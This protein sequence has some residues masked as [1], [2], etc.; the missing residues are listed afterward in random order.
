MS[1]QFM[2][3][4]PDRRDVRQSEGD[5]VLELLFRLVEDADD[6][7]VF[8]DNLRELVFRRDDCF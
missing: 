8:V 4:G 2:R 3:Q 7:A 1:K 6:G 5:L